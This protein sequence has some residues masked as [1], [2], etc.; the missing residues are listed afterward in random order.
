MDWLVDFDK[1]HFT[2]RRALLKQKAEGVPRMLVGLEVDGK[3]PAHDALLLL[4]PGPPGFPLAAQHAV[5]GDRN[6]FNSR[7]NP[8]RQAGTRSFV[9]EQSDSTTLAVGTG[10]TRISLSGTIRVHGKLVDGRSFSAS[11]T[12]AKNGD[13]PF[14]LSFN[15]GMEIII[16]WLNF[17]A[18]EQSS[19]S[20]TV[21]WVNSGTNAF[22][23]SLKVDSL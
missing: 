16:G 12:L 9:L 23:K 8:A 18:G 11:S 13:Y 14:Y 10:S 22:T 2:G 19:S 15:H 17:P 4:G 5:A 21:F 6:V 20:G 1:G 7:V 3:K